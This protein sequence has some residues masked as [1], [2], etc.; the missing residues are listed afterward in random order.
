[1]FYS[2][3][4][5]ISKEIMKSKP[6]HKNNKNKHP[7]N[8]ESKNMKTMRPPKSPLVHNYLLPCQMPKKRKGFRKEKLG[9]NI[10]L[11]INKSLNRNQ[12]RSSLTRNS[13]SS[14]EMQLDLLKKIQKRKE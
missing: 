9:E 2:E 6:I 14:L 5:K 7:L 3:T 8:Q 13:Q 4:A 1:M 12:L 11:G 10:S